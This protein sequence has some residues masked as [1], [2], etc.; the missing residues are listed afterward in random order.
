MIPAQIAP[1][2]SARQ[3]G[4]RKERPPTRDG[5]SSARSSDRPRIAAE[6]RPA[7][8][9]GGGLLHAR[10]RADQLAERLLL[11]PG[12]DSEAARQLQHQPLPG[13]RPGRLARAQPL[14]EVADI[15]PERPGEL[16]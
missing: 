12:K 10:E 13:R 2:A 4:A 16:V 1:G 11:R 15:D 5:P 8:S 14:E 6:P 7:R 3:A 9:G